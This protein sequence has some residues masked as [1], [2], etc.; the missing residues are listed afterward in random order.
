M[1]RGTAQVTDLYTCAACGHTYEKVATADWSDAHAQAEYD[2]TFTPSD[3]LATVC[4]DCYQ[5]LM[6]WVLASPELRDHLR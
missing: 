4:D 1:L 6:S 2:E 5:I 3:D